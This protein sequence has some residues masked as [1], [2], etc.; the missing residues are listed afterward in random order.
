MLCMGLALFFFIKG[1]KQVAN[2]FFYE[3]EGRGERKEYSFSFLGFIFTCHRR[4]ILL[5]M[6]GVEERNKNTSSPS[7]SPYSALPFASCFCFLHRVHLLN[8]E[9][10]IL[11][12]FRSFIPQIPSAKTSLAYKRGI[13]CSRLPNCLIYDSHFRV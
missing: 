12:P 1:K 4:I 3:L 11:L 7:L 8:P 9:R 10:G 2:V 5:V 6:A 13:F